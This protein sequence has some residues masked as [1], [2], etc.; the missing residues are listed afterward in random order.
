MGDR[1]VQR[2]SRR[3]PLPIR[4][5][6]NPTRA[7]VPQDHG[8]V[9][10]W[11]WVEH[12]ITTQ[13]HRHPEDNATALQARFDAGEVVLRDGTPLRPTSLV[14]A[15]QDVW[16]YRMPAPEIP[17][18]YDI[19]VIE[20]DDDLLV[21]D[22]PPFL[23]TMPRARHITETATVRLR[24]VTGND[25]LVPAH[26]L[27]RQ[28]S[29]VLV[30]TQR[31]EVR[32]AYQQLFAERT[33]DKTYE[34]IADHDPGL[35]AAAPLRWASRMH[36]VHGEIQGHIIDGEPNAFT[37][38][39]KVTELTDAEQADIEAVHGPRPRQ[40]RYLLRPETGRTH[41]LRLH[42]WEAGVPILG[43]GVYPVIHPAENED[44]R[45]PLHLVSRELSFVDPFTG[46]RRS[47]T[48]LRERAWG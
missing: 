32:G 27:D 17:I 48:A 43:D 39:E 30:F 36:K 20:E 22:K 10:A 7:R 9:N 31:R 25:D 12:L 11:E 18:P 16:F 38:L 34:A 6:L 1:I 35:A 29:G 44:L 24:R 42:M 23:A 19:R 21:V 33:V 40:A 37:V 5:G 41:Q 45:I 47:F 46:R 13:R 26:R 3:E 28:T 4:D 14:A 8:A 15:G 2:Q